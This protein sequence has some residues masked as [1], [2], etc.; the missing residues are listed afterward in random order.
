M[1]LLTKHLFG[2]FDESGAY[3]DSRFPAFYR[4]AGDLVPTSCT[5]SPVAGNFTRCDVDKDCLDEIEAGQE[6]I[7]S[8]LLYSANKTSFPQVNNKDNV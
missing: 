1:L 5:N 8:S 3:G 6:D 4:E 2:V 7:V